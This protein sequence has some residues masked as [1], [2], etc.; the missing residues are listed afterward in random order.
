MIKIPKLCLNYSLENKQCKFNYDKPIW[1]N[2]ADLDPKCDGTKNETECTWCRKYHIDI[3]NCTL[4]MKKYRAHLR[5]E[6]N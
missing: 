1:I 4:A 2:S 5:G 3:A 6:K